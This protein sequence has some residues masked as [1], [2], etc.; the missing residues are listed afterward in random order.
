[1]SKRKIEF[2]K[3]NLNS[4]KPSK[5]NQNRSPAKPNQIKKSTKEI[6]NK[7]PVNQIKPTKEPTQKIPKPKPNTRP[8]K[9]NQEEIFS[10]FSPF[11]RNG[12]IPENNNRKRKNFYFL[13][14]H[15][16]FK[17]HLIRA[18][19]IFCFVIYFSTV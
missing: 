14:W 4:R 2:T 10:K 9:P 1:M 13:Y 16:F 12:R 6:G 7:L 5:P 8:F 11:S 19:G 17:F 18:L 15:L 3:P